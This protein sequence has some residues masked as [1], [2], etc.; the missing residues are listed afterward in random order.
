MTIKP[1]ITQYQKED[2]YGIYYSFEY[3]NDTGTP[4]EYHIKMVCSEFDAIP[5]LLNT[6][7]TILN[8]LIHPV[9]STFYS[10]ER[11]GETLRFDMNMIGINN[12]QD[13]SLTSIPIQF[14]NHMFKLQVTNKNSYIKYETENTI[15]NVTVNR[16]QQ[17]FVDG[18]A[19]L[20]KADLRNPVNEKYHITYNYIK[21]VEST[22][23][24][25]EDGCV[26][27][28]TLHHQHVMIDVPEW[29]TLTK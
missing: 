5:K 13:W 26:D 18:S 28:L 6:V 25:I 14:A 20:I 8:D 27:L 12:G 24:G 2:E 23:R 10:T 3:P 11:Q 29:T 7:T 17:Q 15:K 22:F 19:I 4:V 1:I 21:C 9:I 16:F